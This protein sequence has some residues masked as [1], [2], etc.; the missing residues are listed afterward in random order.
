MQK[1][2]TFLCF[3]ALILPTQTWAQD[4]DKVEIK[5][6]KVTDNIYSLTGRGGNIGLLVGEDGAFL[7][8]DQYAPLTEKIKAAVAEITD[9]PIKYLVNTHWHGDHSGGNEN[10]SNSGVIIVAHENVRDRLE[11]GQNIKAFSRTVPPAPKAALPVI[12]FS[13]DMNF[14]FNGEK[15]L[16][17]HVHNGH[18][19]GDSFIYFTKSN[20]LHM[21]D[22]FFAGRYP[23]ID[24]SS[25]G[26]FEGLI[27]NV[28]KAMFLTDSDT[29]IIPG[30][31]KVSTKEDLKKYRDVLIDVRDRVAK[32]I[33]SG[34]DLDEIKNANIT[35]DYD[36]EWGQGF[37]KPDRF[38][39]IVHTSMTKE[40]D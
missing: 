20:V 35:K 18:T 38:I 11:K 1:I 4:F 7:I 6:E 36:A 9:K 21:G 40:N 39:D 17:T 29:K 31:G 16:I 13:D 5:A 25:G 34:M 22:N 30:H 15:I 24:L 26:S 27:Q 37:M 19:D 14:F 28:N 10:M 3:I 12:T 32:A 23:Y 2:I 33:K 8:D